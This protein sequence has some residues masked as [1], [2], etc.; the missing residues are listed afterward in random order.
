MADEK[1]V[2]LAE[3]WASEKSPIRILSE[4]DGEYVS[5]EDLPYEDEEDED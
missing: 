4:G 1:S 3:R 2:P 5:Y